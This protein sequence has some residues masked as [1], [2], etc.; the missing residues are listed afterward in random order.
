M[1]QIMLLKIKYVSL[2]LYEFEFVDEIR[3]YKNT[4][5]Y[6]FKFGS[7]MGGDLH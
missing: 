3:G 1:I 7:F 6:M 4:F 2:L 5:E